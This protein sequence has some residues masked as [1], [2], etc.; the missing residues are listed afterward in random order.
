[1][2]MKLRNWNTPHTWM[3]LRSA[4]SR[5]V[6]LAEGGVR[7]S[8]CP[9]MR[10]LMGQFRLKDIIDRCGGHHVRKSMVGSD[11]WA[12]VLC[13]VWYRMVLHFLANVRRE[14]ERERERHSVE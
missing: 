6:Q 14:R 12:V 3:D 5:T 11:G 9:N 7:R 1:M 13:G 8:E 10:R 4:L 2:M